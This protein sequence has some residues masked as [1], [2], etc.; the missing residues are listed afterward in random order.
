MGKQKGMTRVPVLGLLGLLFIEH[1]ATCQLD[2]NTIQ[3]YSVS[4]KVYQV[5]TSLYVHSPS[6]AMVEG[7]AGGGH[8]STIAS[9][10]C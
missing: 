1:S 4:E 6:G 7:A 3:T 10:S 8:F 9:A 5:P 2:T